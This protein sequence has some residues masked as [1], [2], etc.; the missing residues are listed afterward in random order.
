MSDASDATS[1]S[2]TT[3]EPVD[4]Y[5]AAFYT[6]DFPSAAAVLSD[7]FRFEGPFVQTTGRERFL[8]SAQGLRRIVRGHQLVRRW[9]DGSDVCSLYDVTLETPAGSG[10][11][12]MS[13]WHVVDRGLL[14]Q[15][16]VVFDT[17]AFRALLPVI[18]G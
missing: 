15:A 12:R 1:A 17:A 3:T 6:G 13:E 18:A 5:L 16:R 2:T 9:V 8:D 14:A 10:Q 7:D 11:V 4:H